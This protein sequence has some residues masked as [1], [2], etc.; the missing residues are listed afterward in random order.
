MNGPSNLDLLLGR[1]VVKETYPEAGWIGVVQTD[2]LGRQNITHLSRRHDLYLHLAL[3]M[4]NYGTENMRCM[5]NRHS[6][7]K[8]ETIYFIPIEDADTVEL[9][10]TIIM[11]QMDKE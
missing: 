10:K 9:A 8:N 3:A 2:G 7:T 6:A 4:K 1:I 11:H 5:I